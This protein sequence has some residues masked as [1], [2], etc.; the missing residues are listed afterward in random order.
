MLDSTRPAS[1][2]SME[3]S[4]MHDDHK[5]YKDHKHDGETSMSDIKETFKDDFYDE[6]E[7][8]NKYCD[9]AMAAENMGHTELARGL[10]AMSHDEYTHAK[11]IHDNLVDWG[12]E[13]PEKEMMRWHEL[14]ERIRRKFR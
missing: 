1:D 6:I 3:M 8:S 13:I 9:M 12:C 10:Y 2:Y 7:D 5:E 4:S 11:F 14:E